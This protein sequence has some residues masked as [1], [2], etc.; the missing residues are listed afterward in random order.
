[1]LKL[2]QE[3]YLLVKVLYNNESFVVVNNELFVLEDLLLLTC[4]TRMF[5]ICLLQF[6][7]HHLGLDA[8][9]NKVFEQKIM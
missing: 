6:Q 1:M 2:K 3:G 9:L 7:Y 5:G 4:T 8:L